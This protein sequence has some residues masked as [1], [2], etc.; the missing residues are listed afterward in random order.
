MVPNIAHTTQRNQLG[1]G[2]SVYHTALWWSKLQR[3]RERER[4]REGE[5]RLAARSLATQEVCLD[6]IQGKVR[7][8]SNA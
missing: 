7:Y 5:S 6:S 1:R 8:Q 3:K 2:S 4:E